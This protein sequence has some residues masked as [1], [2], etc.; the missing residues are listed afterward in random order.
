MF[1]KISETF[2]N[3]AEKQYAHPKGTHTEISVKFRQ[4]WKSSD[5]LRPFIGV[6]ACTFGAH[7]AKQFG[8]GYFAL[9][10]QTF[11]DKVV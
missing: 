3:R 10:P 11:C 6:G 9:Y 4:E 5:T 1:L 8:V 2:K 7:T